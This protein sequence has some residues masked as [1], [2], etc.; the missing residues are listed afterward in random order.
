MCRINGLIGYSSLD[1]TEKVKS[2]RDVM[3]HGG[4]D[5]SGYYADEA[6]K[7]FLAHRRLSLIDLSDAGHQPMQ[8]SQQDIIIVYN[9]EIYNYKELQQSLIQLGY[10]FK[11]NSDTEVIIASFLEWGINCFEKFNGMFGLALY[12]KRNAKLYLARD[13]AGIKPLYYS[14]RNG[15]LIFASEVRSFKNYDPLWINNPDWRTYLLV[16]GHIPE[17]FTT[18]HEVF[19]LQKGT[20][21]EFDINTLACKTYSFHKAQY[22][23]KIFNEKEATEAIEHTLR[24]SV[25]RHLISDAPI[26][27][28]LSGGIDSSILTLLAK[29]FAGDNLN[30]LSIDFNEANY[31]EKKYQDIIIK[32]TGAKHQRF[33]IT[34]EDFE[35]AIGDILHAMDQPSNDGINTYF[36]TKYA[37]KAGLKAVL[38]GIGADELL[39]GYPSF[40][41]SSLLSKSKLMPVF[42]LHMAEYFNDDKKRKIRFLERKNALGQYLFNRG[43][44][45]PGQ[46]AQILDISVSTVQAAIDKVILPEFINSLAIQE[47][48][49]FTETNLYM[50]N[51]L[52]RD[53]DYMSMWHSVEVRVPFLDKEFMAVCNTIHPSI[54]YKGIPKYL[55]IKAFSNILPEAIW[56]RP[57][58]GFLFPF[59]EWFSSLQLPIANDGKFNTMYAELTSGKIHWSRYWAYC[60]YTISNKDT[61]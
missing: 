6:K 26:G 15:V 14:M 40:K 38:S 20:I 42:L 7:V 51:Q 1:F 35:N 59:K 54:K 57:K 30:T 29:E 3:A 52:L 2:M 45:T 50:Q 61:N 12:D 18:L 11:S 32:Q 39:G 4:P 36:I 10:T 31:S 41:R 60:L 46:V 58:Q 49:S 27:L 21:I 48:V 17:P 25:K 33:T 28:F 34:R 37:Q 13:H 53:T 47:Q 23:Y 56:N 16:F 44:F 43:F 22:E 55:L 8:S 19:S 24:I 5:D 9:G